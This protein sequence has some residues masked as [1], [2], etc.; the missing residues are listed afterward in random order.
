MAQ[1]LRAA[2]RDPWFRRLLLGG[3]IY[4]WFMSQGIP[5][6]DDDFTSWFWKIKDHS[7]FH[8][9]WE[10]ISPISTQP[11]FWGFNERPLEILVYKIFQKI[12]GYD[13]WSYFLYKSG[14]YGG[15]GAMIYAWALRLVPSPRDGKI[16]AALGAVFFLA[17]PGPMAAHVLHQ[18]LAPTAELLFLVLTYLIWEGIEATPESWQGMP[19]WSDPAQ[20]S[21]L[22]R[23]AGI[24]FLTYLAYKSKADLKLIPMI[25]AAYIVLLRR[26]QLGFFA[27]PVGLMLLLAVPWGPGIFT[28]LPP[29]IPGSGGSE[30]G[31]MWQ[32]ASVD[33]FKEFLWSSQGYGFWQGL[34]APTI[35][36]AAILGPFL[37][38]PLLAGL[39]WRAEAFDRVPW[40]RHSSPADRARIFVLLWFGAVLGATSALP[41]INY[42]FRV[43]YG[44]LTLVPGSIL[45][46]WA[47]GLILERRA[48]LVKWALVAG[49]VGFSIQVLVNLNRSVAYRRDMGQVM[50]AVDQAY[51]YVDQKLPTEKVAL[52]P[53]FRPYDYH[54]EAGPWFSAKKQLG[55]LDDLAKGDF[56]AGQTYVISWSPSLWERVEVIQHFTGC[57]KGPF[58]RIWPC[59]AGTGIWLM[60]YLGADAEYAAGEALRAKGKNAEA[61]AVHESFL[62]HH[63]L[64][65]AGLF[66]VG[67]ESMGIQDFARA[68]QVYSLIEEH[69]PDQASSLYNHGLA[70]TELGRPKEAASRFLRVIAGDPRNYGALYNLHLAYK[71][72]GER[73]RA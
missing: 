6:W 28:K 61:R 65:L 29:F 7:I 34:R 18:D 9:V 11:Q 14:V 19:K 45:L 32:P 41:A 48:Q 31:W 27:V 66:V 54:P 60:R 50:V 70:L 39:L 1:S 59:P 17:A 15:L 47:I 56:P 72:A 26:R 3:F 68:D 58:D 21:W 12:S 40:L 24:A 5:L 13:S 69:I 10:W 4:A 2:W 25:L 22:Y 43:R 51:S 37:L 38:L 44:I 33:R 42:I 30:I 8:Y 20:R 64:S 23:W 62:R 63:P 67:L 57:T 16:A 49:M 55:A 36:L 71:R 52:G 35:S 53:G 73:E 46:S